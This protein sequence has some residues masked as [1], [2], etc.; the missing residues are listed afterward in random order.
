VCT[1]SEHQAR[2]IKILQSLCVS[3]KIVETYSNQHT[4]CILSD[5]CQLCSI[6]RLGRVKGRR[7]RRSQDN[8]NKLLWPFSFCWLLHM[9]FESFYLVAALQMWRDL[10]DIDKP[11][12]STGCEKLDV[13]LRGTV[14]V[15][16]SVCFVLCIV[17]V[18][19]VVVCVCV[20]RCVCVCM[21]ARVV[22]ICVCVH[23]LC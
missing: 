10:K 2:T 23:K 20:V 3:H 6:L 17:C 15:V 16:L 4:Q 19:C 7:R 18:L 12:L 21:R 1:H 11:R 22:C 9:Y 13:A 14:V 5:P 8:L